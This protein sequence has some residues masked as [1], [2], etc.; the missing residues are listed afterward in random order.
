MSA[1]L[2]S[3]S[4]QTHLFS[5]TQLLVLGSAATARETR[6]TLTLD[7]P[8]ENFGDCAGQPV[9]YKQCWEVSR[10][11]TSTSLDED[12]NAKHPS[13]LF[14][15]HV[16]WPCIGI[17]SNP[18]I[19]FTQ[20]LV[21]GSAA[22]ARETRLTLMLDEPMENF[23][24]CAGRP[25]YYKQCWEV[26]RAATSTPLA[27]DINAQHPSSLFSGHVSWPRIGIMSNPFIFFTQLLVLCSAATARETRLTL[28][29]DEPLE[30]FGDCAGQPVYYKQCWEVARAATSTSLAED[31]NAQHPSSLF[32][33]HVSWPR[34]GIMS[35]PFIFFTELLV[36]G[37]A[38]TARE[39]RLTLM[40][41]EPLENFGDCAGQPVYYK[42][43]SEDSRAATSTSLAE[44]YK[45][46]ASIEPIQWACQLASHRHHVKPIYF[47]HSVARLGFGSD[48]PRNASHTYAR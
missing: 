4:C 43:C 17:M 27:E 35:N 29:L 41:D 38:A 36:L 45:C 3:A 37:S 14:S 2:A 20:L 18:F 12:I 28:I 19:F 21:L 34:I 16:S 6:L 15:G 10:A 23:G 30:N 42:Q 13:S 26:S 25:V 47:L 33:G 46:T 24:D 9:Y 22:T 44:G 40:L 7:E 11:A 31:I 32:S 8:L 48:G 5:F 39:T 1:G